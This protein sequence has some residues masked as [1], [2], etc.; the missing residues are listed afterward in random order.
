MTFNYFISINKLKL[1]KNPIVTF[2][3]KYLINIK[4]INLTKSEFQIESG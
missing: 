4:I 2:K 3:K 1:N